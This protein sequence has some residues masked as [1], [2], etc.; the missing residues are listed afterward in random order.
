MPWSSPDFNYRR[1]SYF[2]EMFAIDMLTAL[3]P[4]LEHDHKHVPLLRIYGDQA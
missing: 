2:T 1:Y 4:S 3:K